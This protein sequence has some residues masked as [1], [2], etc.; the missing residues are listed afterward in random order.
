METWGEKIV[1]PIMH[2]LLLTLLPLRLVYTS[3]YSSLAAAN[4]QF[5]FFDAKSYYQ[6]QWHS[7]VKTQVTEDIEIVKAIKTRGE[8]AETLLPKGLILCRMYH[9]WNEAINGF[10]K[11]LLAGFGNQIL[12]LVT[13]CFLTTF[14]YFA[15][16]ITFGIAG[17]L[18]SLLLLTIINFGIAKLSQQSFWETSVLHFLRTMSFL[19]IALQSI[20]RKLTKTNTWKGRK[21]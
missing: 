14:A 8:K 13:Y 18:L 6:N 12:F 5:M 11:N 17:I 7:V 3:K 1:V 19:I 20:Y 10:S 21:I 15:V 16:F 2:F 9:N 4:G